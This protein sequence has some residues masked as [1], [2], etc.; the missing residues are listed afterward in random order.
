MRAVTCLL[1]GA[2]LTLSGCDKS[3]QQLARSNAAEP[4]KSETPPSVPPPGTG[5]DAKTP[6]GP[7]EAVDPNSAEAAGQIVRHFGALIEQGRIDGALP[8][9]ASSDSASKFALQL[10]R[11]PE[12]HLEMG[13]PEDEEGAAGSTYVRVP[14]IFFGKDQNDAVFRRPAEVILR[15]VNDVPGSSEAA[16]RWHIERIDWKVAT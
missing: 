6:F 4:G 15:R 7:G 12:V 2:V 10:K 8:L 11:Y 16:R 13:E 1:F 5:P 14:V 9:W 3:S